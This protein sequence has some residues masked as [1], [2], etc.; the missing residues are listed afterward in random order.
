MAFS[1]YVVASRRPP[2]C[3]PAYEYY[4]EHSLIAGALIRMNDAFYK[5]VQS[6]RRSEFLNLNNILQLIKGLLGKKSSS[7]ALATKPDRNPN[8]PLKHHLN[9]KPPN[10]KSITQGPQSGSL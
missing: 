3:E 5:V 7:I 9:P 10:P 8:W 2:K 4:W 1:C 6:V